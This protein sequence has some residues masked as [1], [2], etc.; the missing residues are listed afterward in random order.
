MSNT[1]RLL[2]GLS[3]LAAFAVVRVAQGEEVT[4]A[5]PGDAGVVA[6]APETDARLPGT[7][8]LHRLGRGVV[9]MIIAPLEIPAT[10]LRVAGQTNPVFGILAGGAEGLGNG[11]VRFGAGALETLSAPIPSDGLPLYSKPLG[12]RALPILRPT[13]QITRP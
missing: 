10:M 5:S 2:L 13:T 4:A 6:D 9:N 1:S 8:P 7:G 12:A 3:V 11:L